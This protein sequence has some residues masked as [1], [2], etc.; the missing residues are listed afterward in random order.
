MEKNH[1]QDIPVL[2]DHHHHT[3]KCLIDFLIKRTIQYP[4][5][6]AFSEVDIDLEE[7]P[8]TYSELLFQVKSVCSEL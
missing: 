8:F 4:H 7:K 6:T 1:V 3:D 2:S 5:K